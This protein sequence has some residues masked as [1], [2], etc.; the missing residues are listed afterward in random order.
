MDQ[1]TAMTD[2][3]GPADDNLLQLIASKEKELEAKVAQ[4]KAEAR[5]FADDAQRQVDAIR[6][7]ARREVADLESA[8]QA[9]VAQEAQALASRRLA[10]AQ[11]EAQRVRS[12]AS[13]RMREA[14]TLVVQRVLE[15][16]EEQTPPRE[17]VGKPAR[18]GSDEGRA[19]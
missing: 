14:V 4:A 5:R 3:H 9:A 17:P 15:S 2:K 18:A 8:A 10:A 6:E 12:R 11:A 7:R 13:E 19:P 1:G 16:L